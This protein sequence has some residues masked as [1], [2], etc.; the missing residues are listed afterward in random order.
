M[1]SDQNARVDEEGLHFTMHDPRGLLKV[2]VT[3]AAL[4]TYFGATTEKASWLNAYQAS[5]R[6]IHS[7]AQIHASSR[8]SLYIR[9]GVEEFADMAK[10]EPNE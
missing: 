9:L 1:S 10:L 4:T 3:A 6:Q 8:P 2:Q 7:V 5:Y